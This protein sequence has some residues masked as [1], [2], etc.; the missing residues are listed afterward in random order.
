[1]S[2]QRSLQ[3]GRQRCSGVH[4]MGLPQVGHLTMGFMN[5]TEGPHS[6][7]YIETVPRIESAR[8]LREIE[9]AAKRK[10]YGRPI[11]VG[12][13]ADL[14]LDKPAVQGEKLHPHNRCSRQSG[15]G[16]VH[17]GSVKRPRIVLATGHH[18]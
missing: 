2:L 11:T 14:S 7:P 5:R 8:V 4:S 12:K 18:R 3:N 1:M 6:G 15:F 17:N 13:D 9:E 16:I 10:L